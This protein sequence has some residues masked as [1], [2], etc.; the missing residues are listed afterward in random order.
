M[1]NE[2]LKEKIYIVLAVVLTVLFLATAS[3]AW[4]DQS[5]LQFKLTKKTN[6]FSFGGHAEI[7]TRYDGTYYQHLHANADWKVIKNLKVGLAYRFVRFDIDLDKGFGDWTFDE[8]WKYEH[9]PMINA[10]YKWKFIKNRARISYRILPG[11]NRARFRNKTTVTVGPVYVA[12]EL[13][14]E[15]KKVGIYRDRKY[16]GVKIEF[17]NLFVMWQ[18]TLDKRILI[19]II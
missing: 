11:I 16:I 8:I 9:R 1:K 15:Y 4:V 5:W 12:Y 19:S 7:R 14:M 3:H 18:R 6:G 17:L 2:F 10:E 13:F